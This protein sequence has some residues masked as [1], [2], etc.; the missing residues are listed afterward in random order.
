VGVVPGDP[1]IWS[2]FAEA[3][4]DLAAFVEPRLNGDAPSY[5]ATVRS[6]ALPR[7]HPVAVRARNGRLG[8]YMYPS[9]P[10]HHDLVADGRY[11]LHASVA[12]HDGTGGEAH[13]RG[14]AR[15][16]TDPHHTAEMTDAG[17]PPRDGFVLHEL[18]V[19]SV[20]VCTYDGPDA[21]AN[22]RRWTA[23]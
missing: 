14:R 18:L 22:I 12:D 2:R 9:S 17:F 20:L 4:P 6:D 11:A 1:T 16:V 7:V 3:E 5:L 23:P 15:H 19:T 21:T 13:L 8:V 10:K